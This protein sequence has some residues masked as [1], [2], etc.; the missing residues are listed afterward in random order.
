[1]IGHGCVGEHASG[2]NVVAEPH[3]SKLEAFA[4]EAF[5]I[6]LRHRQ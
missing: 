2:S 4:A 6:R 5:H 1:M 3:L